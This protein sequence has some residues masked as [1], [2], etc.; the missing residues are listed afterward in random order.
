MFQVLTIAGG[1][2]RLHVGRPK[3]GEGDAKKDNVSS[4]LS[5][6]PA[7]KPGFLHLPGELRNVIYELVTATHT[8]RVISK[9]KKQ[10]PGLVGRHPLSLACRQTRKEF[11]GIFAAHA[12]YLSCNGPLNTAVYDFHFGPLLDFLGKHPAPDPSLVRTQWVQHVSYA[13][14]LRFKVNKRTYEIN[15]T[16]VAPRSYHE[17]NGKCCFQLVQQMSVA[18]IYLRGKPKGHRRALEGLKDAIM[19]DHNNCMASRRDESKPARKPMNPKK[20]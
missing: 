16:V 8:I 15:Y 20:A 19:L 12:S 9:E 11:R 5:Q 13:D 18:P 3:H 17:V 10:G 4:H 2:Q 6:I 1:H 7:K 14:G